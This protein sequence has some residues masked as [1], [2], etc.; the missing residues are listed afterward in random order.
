LPM[1]SW[2]HDSIRERRSYLNLVRAPEDCRKWLDKPLGQINTARF[3]LG[4]VEGRDP[5]YLPEHTYMSTYV[6]GPDTGKVRL[7]PDF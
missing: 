3:V 1:A 2:T 5:Q 7:Q 6:A 4:C